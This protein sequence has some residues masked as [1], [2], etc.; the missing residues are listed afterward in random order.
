MEEM[1]S[2]FIERLD[3]RINRA[4]ARLENGALGLGPF[5]ELVA[6]IMCYNP[7]RHCA[8]GQAPDLASPTL[9]ARRRGAPPPRA[10]QIDSDSC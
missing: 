7:Q 5:L 4:T 2:V 8:Q 3:A 6:H 9:T 10:Q 1:K